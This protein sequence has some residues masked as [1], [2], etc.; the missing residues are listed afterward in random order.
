MSGRLSYPPS[1]TPSPHQGGHV[2]RAACH[3]F[4]S[5]AEGIVWA[6]AELAVRALLVSG[7]AVVID[8]TNTTR[9]AGWLRI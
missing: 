6:V 9:R 1:Q 2:S 7:H 3:A 5:P 8:A 4:H